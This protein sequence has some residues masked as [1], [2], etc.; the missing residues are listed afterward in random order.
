MCFG[1]EDHTEATT[2]ETSPAGH[3]Y[4]EDATA[5]GGS[6]IYELTGREEK[7]TNGSTKEHTTRENTGKG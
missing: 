7:H 3:T 4:T 2:R 6:L 1:T 5:T